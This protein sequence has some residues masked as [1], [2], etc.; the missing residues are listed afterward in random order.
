ML[1]LTRTEFIQY[2]ARLFIIFL[3]LP[4]HECAHAWTARRLGDDTAYYQGRVTLNPIAHIDPIGALLLLLTGFGWAKPVPID[5][6]RF[7]RRHSMRFGVAIT[8]LAGPVSNLLAALV[9]QIVL[10][11]YECSSYYQNYIQST[12]TV[13]GMADTPYLIDTFIYYYIVINVGLAVF[14]LVPIPPLDGSKV[15]SYF[16]SARVDDWFRRN[17][18]IVRIVFLVIV[19]SGLLSWPLAYIRNL[20]MS[21]LSAITAWIPRLFR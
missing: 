11:F 5:P 21:F 9:G 17:A 13:N 19:L 7:D 14:N 8:A 2:A 6:T 10:R 1:Q 12:G 18:Q 3:I 15:L 16:T 4:L 20:I